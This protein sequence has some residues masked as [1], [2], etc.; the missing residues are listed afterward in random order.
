[1]GESNS[2]LPDANRMHCHYANGP[3]KKL[4]T[5]AYLYLTSRDDT[6]DKYCS[7]HF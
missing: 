3:P 2:R 5:N 4:I 1:M 6:V 7:T